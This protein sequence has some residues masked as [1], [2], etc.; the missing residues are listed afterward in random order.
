MAQDLATLY[1]QGRVLTM[2]EDL[3]EL[4]DKNKDLVTLFLH[5]LVDKN[6]HDVELNDAV[7]SISELRQ[8]DHRLVGV[9][10]DLNNLVV[11]KETDLGYHLILHD[12]EP[13]LL[14]A[15]AFDYGSGCKFPDDVIALFK[16]VDEL[17]HYLGGVEGQVE[18]IALMEVLVDFF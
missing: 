11:E 15:A 14:R 12:E 4:K 17:K 9:G 3:N 5:Q 2:Q 16:T 1:H 18:L 6:R 7:D 8:I 13:C 10:S